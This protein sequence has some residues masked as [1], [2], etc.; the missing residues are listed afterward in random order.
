MISGYKIGIEGN[1]YHGMVKG[2]DN[3]R[4]YQ[5]LREGSAYNSQWIETRSYKLWVAQK[6]S[7]I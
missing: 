3:R 1:G 7:K 6:L 4:C 2:A 5:P